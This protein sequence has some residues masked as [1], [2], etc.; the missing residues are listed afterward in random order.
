MDESAQHSQLIGCPRGFLPS[1]MLSGWSTKVEMDGF[2]KELARYDDFWDSVY[3]RTFTKKDGDIFVPDSSVVGADLA[4][5][6]RVQVKFCFQLT[7]SNMGGEF[8]EP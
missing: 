6:Q 7:N 2:I 5:F 8:F 3:K 4:G 1:R